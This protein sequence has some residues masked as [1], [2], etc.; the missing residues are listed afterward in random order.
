MEGDEGRRSTEPSRCFH[1]FSATPANT[2][3]PP[4]K[5]NKVKAVMFL[6]DLSQDPREPVT[7][8]EVLDGSKGVGIRCTETECFIL[9]LSF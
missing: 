3:P 8:H 2:A 7:H 5:K 9:Y 4:P 6:N 1:G